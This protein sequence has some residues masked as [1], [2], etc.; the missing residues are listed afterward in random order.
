[1][2]RIRILLV[3][4]HPVVREGIKTLFSQHEGIEVVGEAGNGEEALDKVRELSPDVVLMDISM[5][6]M[7]GID[8][9]VVL[10]R[11]CPD[12]KILILTMHDDKEYVLQ[13][14]RSGAHGYVLKDSP[15]DELVRAV[16]TVAEGQVYFS[17]QASQAIVNDYVK[18][19]GEAERME[20]P[21]LSK[22]ETEVLS[23]VAEGLSNKE[24]AAKLFL[25]ARTVE[26]HRERIMAKLGIKSVAGL[27]KYAISKGIVKLR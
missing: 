26:T 11:E 15:P 4:D 6:L 9:T 5:P 14:T 2:E 22:R 12:A 27:T 7:N 21:A 25:S 10:R 16:R 17:P 1:M 8:A 24:I 20:M 18:A 19:S 23:L 13:I 3:D